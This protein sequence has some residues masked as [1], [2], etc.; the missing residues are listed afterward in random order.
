MWM[1]R[2]KT[3]LE[4]TE[5]ELSYWDNVPADVEITAFALAL[6]RHGGQSPFIVEITGYEEVCCA[7]V[8]QAIMGGSS[9]IVGRAIYCVKNNSVNELRISNNGISLRTY[10]REKLELRPSCLRKMVG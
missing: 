1:L 4:I 8:G 5:K 10:P 3:G 7:I 2:L 6:H 9:N